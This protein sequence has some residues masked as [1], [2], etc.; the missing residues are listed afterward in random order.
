MPKLGLMSLSQVEKN[1]TMS[2]CPLKA[3]IHQHKPNPSYIHAYS[4]HLTAGIGLANRIIQITINYCS[5]VHIVSNAPSRS[6]SCALAC[7]VLSFNS[8]ASCIT[9][10]MIALSSVSGAS[11]LTAVES[12]TQTTADPMSQTPQLKCQTGLLR[13]LKYQTKLARDGKHGMW[14]PGSVQAKL[15]EPTCARS[16]TDSKVNLLATLTCQAI[17]MCWNKRCCCVVRIEGVS[18]LF[19]DDEHAKFSKL[20]NRARKCVYTSPAHWNTPTLSIVRK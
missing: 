18:V 16:L 13:N 1:W 15:W 5:R 19:S 3:R 14:D 20:C 4:C 12:S 2:G 11:I 10:F 7:L 17:K 9:S 8:S 6:P